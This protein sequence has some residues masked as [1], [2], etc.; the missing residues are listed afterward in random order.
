[1]TCTPIGMTPACGTGT[2]T[3]GSPINEI[4]WVIDADVRPQQHF[5]P[6]EHK[7]P[8]PD[9]RCDTG[10]RGCQ[11]RIHLV[12]QAQHPV[13]VPAAEFL[14]LHQPGGRHH[15]AGNQPVAHIGIEVASL[16][17]QPVQMQGAG[18]G[19]GDDIGR[20]AGPRGFGDLD[21]AGDTEG[22]G[23]IVNCSQRFRSGANPEVT[24]GSGNAQAVAAAM[25]ARRDRWIEPIGAGGIEWIGPGRR[26]VGDRQVHRAARQ[27]TEVIEAG[28]EREAAGARQAPKSRL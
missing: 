22:A 23:D 25:H 16:S 15:G 6:L 20:L 12:E 28:D 3:T 26:I 19:C 7:G 9:R 5:L 14:R 27:G 17:A 18:F 8:L 13:A 11:D 1:M 2:A 4:G 24:A 10:C 21:L